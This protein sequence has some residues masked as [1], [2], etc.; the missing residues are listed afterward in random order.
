MRVALAGQ[1]NCGKSTLFNRIAGYKA[2]TANFP[3]T[4]VT[5]T[6][7]QTR[8]NGVTCTCVDLPGP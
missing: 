4:S 2:V 8:I 6:E 5:F 7:T 1:P 3:G